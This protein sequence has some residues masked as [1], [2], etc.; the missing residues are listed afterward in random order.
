MREAW[1]LRAAVTPPYL[2]ESKLTDLSRD[3]FR[4]GPVQASAVCCVS[5]PGASAALNVRRDGRCC[6]AGTVDSSRDEIEQ[7]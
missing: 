2:L 6:G 1:A 7:G 4:G 3:A 5:E